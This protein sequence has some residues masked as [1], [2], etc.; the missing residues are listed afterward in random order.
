MAEFVRGGTNAEGA[1]VVRM[2]GEVDLDGARGL[3]EAVKPCLSNGEN[4][5][6]DLAGLKFIDSTGLGT[7]VQLRKEAAKAGASLRLKNVSPSIH[8]LFEATGLAPFFGVSQRVATPPPG[9]STDG[10]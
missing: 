2:V 3:V 8:R 7:L 9:N 4:V 10:A 6:L 1:T 5:E